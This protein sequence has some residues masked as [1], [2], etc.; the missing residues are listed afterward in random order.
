LRVNVS[1]GT[2]S[3]FGKGGHQILMDLGLELM[4]EAIAD[5]NIR[6]MYRINITN[7]K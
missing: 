6:E 4:E 1:I 7:K 2:N 5:V 3:K